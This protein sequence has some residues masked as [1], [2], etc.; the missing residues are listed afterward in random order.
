V[1]GV[2]ERGEAGEL[3]NTGVLI[4]AGGLRAAYRKAHLWD[5]EKAVF[6]PGSALPPVVDT[7]VGRIGV[8]VCYDLEFPE[9]VRTVALRGADLLCAPVNWPLAPRPAGE[10]PAEIV[11]VRANAAVNRMFVA[12]CDRAGSERGVEW[13]GGS[14]I[15]DAD[16]FRAAGPLPRYDEGMLIAELAL[17]EA[18]DKRLSD[19]NDVLTDRRPELYRSIT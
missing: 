2:C 11:R 19:H 8:M 16:G 10:Q 17:G 6:T 7:A 5:T 4:D 13:T 3:H 18:R 1:G 14:V 15:A 12:A 9:W